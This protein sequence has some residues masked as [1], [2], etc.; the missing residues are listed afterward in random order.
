MTTNATPNDAWHEPGEAL[1]TVAELAAFLGVPVATIY[2]WR[3]QHQGPIGYRIGRHVR[4]RT[5]DIE[6]W[7]VTQRDDHKDL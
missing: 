7:L 1:L 6:Q 2:R 3:H 5:R 4:Y